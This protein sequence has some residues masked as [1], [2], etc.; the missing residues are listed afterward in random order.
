[1]E[2]GKES[3]K[4]AVEK[5]LRG[6]QRGLLH[7]VVRELLGFKGFQRREIVAYST[8]TQV[9]ASV[10]IYIHGMYNLYK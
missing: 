6:N 4:L 5:F 2:H 7:E 8:Y 3:V 10:Y 9:I 1:M